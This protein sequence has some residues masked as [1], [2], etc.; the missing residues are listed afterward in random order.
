M[1]IVITSLEAEQF[2][3]LKAV[4]LEPGSKGLTVIGGK[5]GAGKTSVLDA[6]AFALG[7]AKFKP[8]EAK[9]RDSGEEE[10]HIRVELSN[11]LVVERSGAKGT[12]KVTDSTGMKGTQGVLDEVIEALA[13]DLPKFME[14]TG[15]QKAETLLQ[16]IGAGDKL[17]LL[18]GRES[19]IYD[20]RR[21]V[22]KVADTLEKALKGMEHSEDIHMQPVSTLEIIA[23]MK[24]AEGLRTQRDTL[25][26]QKKEYLEQ[27]DHHKE[28]LSEYQASIEQVIDPSLA[29]IKVPETSE[30]AD[31]LSEAE[32]ANRQVQANAY[33]IE[34]E[35]EAKGQ[36][37]LHAR[38]GKDLDT[39]RASRQKLLAEADM[40]LPEL[41]VVDG[42]LEYKGA[43][44]DCMSSAEQL[45]VATAIVR[46]LQPECGFVLI[47]KLER[48]DLDTLAEFGKW[49][50]GEGLQILA[51]RVSTGDECSVVI[52]DGQVSG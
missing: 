43:K 35:S 32:E 44:W 41:S 40:P 37:D 33:Y 11:G 34:K 31:K 26:A 3:R 20:T 8:S 4:R 27:I 2:K 52:E 21:D 48:M 7:G 16:I 22:G 47:D 1:G 50:K 15:K 36:R 14:G 25:L 9:N 13:L 30:L 12:L 28:Q 19:K 24:T 6:I 42:E 49:A 39:V 10:A 46:K 51:T 45:K 17:A 38:L 5:N 23:E 18:D 29:K